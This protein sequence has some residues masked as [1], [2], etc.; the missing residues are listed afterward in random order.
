MCMVNHECEITFW[1]SSRIKPWKMKT[2]TPSTKKDRFSF[3]D[4]L[5]CWC[6]TWTIFICL[7][8]YASRFLP[9]RGVSISSTH[10]GFPASPQVATFFQFCSFG[11]L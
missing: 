10:S 8:S 4:L 5:L 2:D 6:C 7:W 3:Q 9:R 1:R 11:I